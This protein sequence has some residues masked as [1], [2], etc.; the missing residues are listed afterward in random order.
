MMMITD[1]MEGDWVLH[2]IRQRLAVPIDSSQ[3]SRPHRLTSD[4][5]HLALHVDG[6][7]ALY[8]AR[9]GWSDI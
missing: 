1:R 5:Q 7:R 6:Q 8:A 2:Q 4:G 3:S 9:V